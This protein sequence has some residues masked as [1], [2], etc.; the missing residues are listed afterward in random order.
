MADHLDIMSRWTLVF[1]SPVEFNGRGACKRPQVLIQP[2]SALSLPR[3]IKI[4]IRIHIH[5]VD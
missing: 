3:L 4:C 5:H 1:E 2:P